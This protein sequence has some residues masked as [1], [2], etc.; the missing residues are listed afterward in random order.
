[1]IANAV[2]SIVSS[3]IGCEPEDLHE[4]MALAVEFHPS[5]EDMLLPYFRPLGVDPAS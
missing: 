5:S 3:I 4:G 2:L 1:M